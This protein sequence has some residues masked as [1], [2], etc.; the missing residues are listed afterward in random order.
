MGQEKKLH[1]YKLL[2]SDCQQVNLCVTKA[3]NM[4]SLSVDNDTGDLGLHI[5]MMLQLMFL[6]AVTINLKL[7]LQDFKPVC[8]SAVSG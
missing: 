3:G 8:T 4:S 7:Q 5:H 2:K 1:L 6:L